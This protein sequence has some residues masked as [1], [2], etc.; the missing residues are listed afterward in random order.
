MGDQFTIAGLR[1]KRRH[2]AEEIEA[3]K[4]AIT[5]QRALLA[6]LDAT[7]LLFDTTGDP[8]LIPAVRPVQRGN[9]FRHGEQV[10]L[11]L[12]ALRNAGRALSVKDVTECVAAGRGLDPKD[13]PLRLILERQV[14]DAL[15]R[16]TRRGVV[17]RFEGKPV[18]FGVV[19]ARGER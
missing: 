6:N 14:R 2:L 10:R 7:L 3:A 13:C 9:I 19:P 4:R 16:M 1:R 5:R 8:S 12:E 18:M 15:M 11:A 17:F